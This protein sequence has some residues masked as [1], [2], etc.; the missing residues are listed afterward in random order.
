MQKVCLTGRSGI[1]MNAV[2]EVEKEL[3]IGRDA[4]MCQLVYPETAKEICARIAVAID[5]LDVLPCRF[6]L[7]DKEPWHS[8]GLRKLI[9]GNF[10]VFYIPMEKLAEVVILAIMYGR[11][12]IANVLEEK[13]DP[14]H[15][16]P[17]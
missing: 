13:D 9:V 16:D 4:N 12:D 7:Y 2:L 1:Y 6:P 8:R 14:M 17:L 3:L 10:I 5:G 11:R 15:D